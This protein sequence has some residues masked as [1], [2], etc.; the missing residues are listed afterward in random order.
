MIWAI[1]ILCI[2]GWVLSFFTDVSVYGYTTETVVANRVTYMFFHRS[3]LHFLGNMIA[4]WFC[5][6]S[7]KRFGAKYAEWLIL[8]VCFLVTFGSEFPQPTIGISGAVY[9]Y[10]GIVLTYCKNKDYIISLLI[11][12]LT[13]IVLFY[14]QSSNM[15]VHALSFIY[16][17]IFSNIIIWT[18]KKVTRRGLMRN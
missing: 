9:M 15:F 4:L 3:V 18:Q 14:F 16:G 12:A 7:A 5:H 17:F 6:R 1:Y 13:N 10:L 2:A 11:V 8:P